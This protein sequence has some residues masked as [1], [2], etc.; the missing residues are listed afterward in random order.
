ME[1]V[2]YIFKIVIIG[3]AG[4]GKSNILTRYTRNEFDS[5]NNPTIGIEFSSKTTVIDGHSTKLQI[6]AS[7]LTLSGILPAKNVTGQLPSLTTR[8]PTG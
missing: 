1:D 4:V 6:V 7:F 8:E 3:D 5:G 2:E